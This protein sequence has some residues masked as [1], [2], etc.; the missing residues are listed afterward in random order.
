[1]YV[2]KDCV[3]TNAYTCMEQGIKPL[4]DGWEGSGERERVCGGVGGGGG[5]EGG[6]EYGR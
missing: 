4:C 6:I 2:C 5:G 1:M 3:C